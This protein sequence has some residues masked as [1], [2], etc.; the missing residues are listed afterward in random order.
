MGACCTSSPTEAP[1]ID[2]NPK[3][4]TV[5][6]GEFSTKADDRETAAL[7]VQSYYRGVMARRTVEETYG[8]KAETMAQVKAA[9]FTQSDAQV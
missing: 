3:P 7:K 2:S 1:E 6:G 5:K 9:T 4:S 8:F